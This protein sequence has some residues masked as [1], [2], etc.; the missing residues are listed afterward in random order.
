MAVSNFKQIDTHNY[1]AGIYLFKLDNGS[2]RTM[3]KILSKLTIK[4]PEGHHIHRS[5]IF[6]VK[7]EQISHI[8]LLFP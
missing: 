8:H 7:F 2:T 6:I 1:P 3:Y 4:T 5:G